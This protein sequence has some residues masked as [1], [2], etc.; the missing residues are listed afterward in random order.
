M[1][2]EIKASEKAKRTVNPIRAI[3]DK[4]LAG[5]VVIRGKQVPFA[6]ETY[7]EVDGQL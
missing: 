2:F 7:S 6:L 1:P 3:V 4:V 5:E